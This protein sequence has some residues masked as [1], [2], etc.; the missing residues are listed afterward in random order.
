M[1]GDKDR[2]PGV[3]GVVVAAA[4]DLVDLQ[5][6][7]G[8]TGHGPE[9][10]GEERGRVVWSGPKQVGQLPERLGQQDLPGELSR[11]GRTRGSAAGS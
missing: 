1:E 9:P 10:P 8:A 4:L 2:Q 11:G 6:E 7:C 5:S 3:L